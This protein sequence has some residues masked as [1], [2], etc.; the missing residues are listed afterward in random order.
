MKRFFVLSAL[1]VSLCLNSCDERPKLGILDK[2]QTEEFYNV[3]CKDYEYLLFETG[4][5]LEY[6]DY[7]INPLNDA[8][9]E[10]AQELQKKQSAWENRELGKFVTALLGGQSSDYKAQ[11]QNEIIAKFKMNCT[12]YK[13]IM[14]G[15]KMKQ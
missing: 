12:E 10:Y 5:G 1:F 9:N 6:D 7:I 13:R 15:L 4:I 2:D 8:I 14:W 3:I 11:D